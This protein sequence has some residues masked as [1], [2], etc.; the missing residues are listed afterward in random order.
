LIVFKA[1]L[2]LKQNH[3]SGKIA[4]TVVKYH[5]LWKNLES[6]S[7]AGY[8][9]GYCVYELGTSTG[10]GMVL[11]CFQAHPGSTLGVLGMNPM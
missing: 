9:T 4:E 8:V 10:T 11:V 3:I 5:S 6:P 2:L 7:I 1:E